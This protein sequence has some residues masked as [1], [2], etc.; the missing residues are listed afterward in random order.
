[1][2]TPETSETPSAPESA[3]DPQTLSP[4]ETTELPG[5]VG[6]HPNDG[7]PVHFRCT[8]CNKRDAW[9]RRHG[10][11]TIPIC[12]RCRTLNWEINGALWGVVADSSLAFKRAAATSTTFMMQSGMW[13]ILTMF[14]DAMRVRMADGSFTDQYCVGCEQ[15]AHAGGPFQCT[16]ACHKAWELRKELE[17]KVA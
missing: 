1:M 4:E 8:N 12:R 7:E 13:E 6:V 10:K 11:L 14:M 5:Q 15:N 16:C 3:L 17:A 2:Q 9:Y